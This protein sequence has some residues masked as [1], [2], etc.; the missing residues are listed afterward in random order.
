[1]TQYDDSHDA[2]DS[3]PENDR[4]DVWDF[5][6]LLAYRINSLTVFYVGS[7]HNYRDLNLV[8]DG[9]EGWGLTERQFFMKLQYLFQI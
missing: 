3:D 8:G 5:D 9:R 1:V 7:T 6:P 4:H 2:W